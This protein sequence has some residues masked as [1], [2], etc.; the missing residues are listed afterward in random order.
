MT[1]PEALCTVSFV[2][3]YT[4]TVSAS[5]D[6]FLVGSIVPAATPEAVIPRTWAMPAA[7]PS[8]GIV[9][10]VDQFGTAFS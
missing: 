4:E 7:L 8:G 3:D 6:S 10:E 5:G 9:A 2:L 1:C